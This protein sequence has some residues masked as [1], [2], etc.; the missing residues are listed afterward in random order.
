MSQHRLWLAAA[1]LWFLGL[2]FLV[3]FG[4]VARWGVYPVA[5]AWALLV[6]LSKRAR[7]VSP[8]LV[9]ALAAATYLAA[10]AVAGAPL[11]APSSA[12]EIV[13]LVGTVVV[14]RGLAGCEDQ[15]EQAVR[16]SLSGDLPTESRAADA[17]HNKLYTE[18][19]RARAHERPVSLLAI[20][21]A[22]TGSARMDPLVEEIVRDHVRDYVRARLA[23]LLSSEMRDFDILAVHH[24]HLVTM[25]PETSTE[26]AMHFVRRLRAGAR[27]QLGL[28][29]DVGLSS[30][31]AQE[32][33]LDALLERAESAMRTGSDRAAEGTQPLGAVPGQWQA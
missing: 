3:G 28:E 2:S 18:L 14:A 12:F 25:L 27:E 31:P 4:H 15:L 20:A 22:G 8:W 33:T 23:E 10:N 26:Q 30:F 32:V 19:R 1:L 11:L 6:V 21:P 24:D 17:G 16:F 13:A 29:L 7:R 5:L 9:G